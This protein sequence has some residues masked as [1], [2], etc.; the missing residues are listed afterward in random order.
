[1]GIIDEESRILLL[2]S[3][4]LV[5]V[6]NTP[7]GCVTTCNVT[8]RSSVLLTHLQVVAYLQQKIS[9]RGLY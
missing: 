7:K 3:A 2:R 6:S 9:Q 1:M 5:I 4:D 8:Q